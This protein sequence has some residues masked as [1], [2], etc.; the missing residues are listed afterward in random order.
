[1]GPFSPK[2]REKKDRCFPFLSPSGRV[3]GPL[4]RAWR[5]NGK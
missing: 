4:L 2:G 5:S 1:M 3:R